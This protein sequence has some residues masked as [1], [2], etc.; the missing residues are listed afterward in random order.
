MWKEFRRQSSH[1]EVMRGYRQIL[2][3]SEHMRSEMSRHGLRADVVSYPVAMHAAANGDGN[4]RSLRLLCAA[5][6]DQ[7]KGG[8]FL[9]D[10]LSA[11]VARASRPVSVTFAGD[12]PDRSGLET[13][14]QQLQSDVVQTK[15]TGWISHE[16]MSELLQE[17]DLLVVPSVWPEPFGSIGPFAAQYGVPAAAFD[18]GGIRSWLTDGVGGHLAPGNPPTARGLADAILRCVAD[19]RHHAE[20]RRGARESALRFTMASHLPALMTSLEHAAHR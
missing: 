20:L 17:T 12:G 3:H 6:L 7:L 10:A 15:F 11:I 4:S 1:L 14:A 8:A 16:R 19:P 2:T 9:L 5:R 13:R 18:V